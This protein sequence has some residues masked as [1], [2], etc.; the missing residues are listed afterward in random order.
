MCWGLCLSACSLFRPALSV[1]VCRVLFGLCAFLLVSSGVAGVSWP[2]AGV[3]FSFL[4][5]FVRF[6]LCC[7]GLLRIG[8]F[9]PGSVPPLSCPPPRLVP[10]RL[11]VQ[12]V[13][14]WS[15]PRYLVVFFF[16]S[17]PVAFRR[18]YGLESYS[19]TSGESNRHRKSVSTARVMP[20]QLHHEDDSLGIWLYLATARLSCLWYRV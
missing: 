9:S 11:L 16:L 2:L 3:V 10:W 8:S 19:R 4:C 15:L 18:V 1:L 6:C 5:C 13:S 7:L 17:E 12:S 14:C 20:Y